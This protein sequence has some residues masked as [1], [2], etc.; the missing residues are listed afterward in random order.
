VVTQTYRNFLHI[1][2]DDCSTDGTS[3]IVTKV[4][5]ERKNDGN[6]MLIR[7]D[8]WTHSPLAS[9]VKGVLSVPSDKNDIIVTIDGDDWLTCDDALEC[10]NGVYQDTEVWMTYG[11]FKSVSGALNG[12]CQPLSD[13]RTYRK[14]TWTTAHLRTIKRK[15]FDRINIDDLRDKNGEF[16]TM[17]L[18][19]AYIYP[20]VEM[21]G[22]KHIR[23]IDK[24]LYVYND[25]NPLC[26]IFDF[27]NGFLKN[28]N[29]QKE[30]Y[31]VEYE[32][33][34]KKQ[35]DELTEL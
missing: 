32:I 8:T 14:A 10:V 34:N 29:L 9:F 17:Y 30:A 27:E 33:R 18:D 25:M 15:L 21:S 20:C 22:L 4:A 31:A 3:D 19:T 2:V 16:Y 35:Y 12:Y 28:K 23:L 13:T 11:S 6:F 7:N 26:S 1:V 24:I 5:E